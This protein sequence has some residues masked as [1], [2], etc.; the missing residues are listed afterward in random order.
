MVE[1]VMFEV[2]DGSKMTLS[3]ILDTINDDS[4]AVVG[5]FVRAVCGFDHEDV[6]PGCRTGVGE[7]VAKHYWRTGRW[8]DGV[9]EALDTAI[10]AAKRR[11]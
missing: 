9:T 6:C 3:E 4:D 8:P 10:E 2:S 5:D 1:G 7:C 11:S